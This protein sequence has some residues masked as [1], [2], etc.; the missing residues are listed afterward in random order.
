MR[1]LLAAGLLATAIVQWGCGTCRAIS[2]GGKTFTCDQEDSPWT[3]A[4]RESAA[5]DLDCPSE[6]ITVTPIGHGKYPASD[7]LADGCGMRASYDCE[8]A[9]LTQTCTMILVS[10]F[11]VK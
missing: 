5:R 8:P 11:T 10:K 9:S 6:S 4:A 1:K 7:Y 3:H 2:T